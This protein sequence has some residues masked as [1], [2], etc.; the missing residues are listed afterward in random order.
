MTASA[1]IASS[2]PSSRAIRTP[3]TLDYSGSAAAPFTIQNPFP[4]LP[5]GPVRP[6]LGQSRTTLA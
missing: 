4:N 6:A 3:T 1:P 5:L 2:T